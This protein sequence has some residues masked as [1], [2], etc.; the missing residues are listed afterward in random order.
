MINLAK[1]VSNYRMLGWVGVP[2]HVWSLLFQELFAIHI[3]EILH[4]FFIQKELVS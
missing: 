2:M 3:D 1:I 4:E